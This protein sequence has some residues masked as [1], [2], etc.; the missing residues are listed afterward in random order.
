MVSVV[1]IANIPNV[2]LNVL[3]A[4]LDILTAINGDPSISN[5]ML[6]AFYSL[7]KCTHIIKC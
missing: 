5:L 2:H 1:P 4:L 3:F 6:V 7:T